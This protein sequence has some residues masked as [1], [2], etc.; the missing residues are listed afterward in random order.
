MS[1]NEIA[2]QIG[3]IIIGFS[4][5]A[6][7]GAIVLKIVSKIKND[8]RYIISFRGNYKAVSVPVIRMKL[9]DNKWHNFIVDT[10]SNCCI[11][12]VDTYKC[13]EDKVSDKKLIKDTFS[14]IGDTSKMSNTLTTITTDLRIYKTVFPNI[15]FKVLEIASFKSIKDKTG[16]HIDGI[17]GCD[18]MAKYG[19]EVDL[20]NFVVYIGNGKEIERHPR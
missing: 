2:A 6:F 8:Y 14:G 16:L 9:C 18:L 19:W 4:I 17:I 3:F 15:N 10:G 13:I 11:L 1:G 20:E 12:S 5:V 7:V